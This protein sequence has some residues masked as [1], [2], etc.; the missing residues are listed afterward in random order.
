[1]DRECGKDR[2]IS[3]HTVNSAVGFGKIVFLEEN[4]IA[5]ERFN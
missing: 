2:T 4:D 1:M 3:N 5:I